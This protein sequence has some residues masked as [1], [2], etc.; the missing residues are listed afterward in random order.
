MPADNTARLAGSSTSAI[1]WMVPATKAPDKSVVD[2][3]VT[4][5]QYYGLCS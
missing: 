3:Q 1:R 5:G 4:P 2:E